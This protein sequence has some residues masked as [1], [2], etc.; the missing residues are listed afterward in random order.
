ME[1]AADDT[2]KILLCGSPR[3]GKTSILKVV[4]S[5]MSPHETL[6][7]EST[8]K[9]EVTPVARN[10]LMRFKVLDFPGSMSF[11]ESSEGW[12][13]KTG[14]VVFVIDAQ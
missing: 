8:P 3:A 6:F 12:F 14:A 4:F 10:A 13:T 1:D 9:P 7:L 11:D 5:K 2:P